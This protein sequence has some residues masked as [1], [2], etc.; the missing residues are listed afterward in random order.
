VFLRLVQSAGNTQVFCGLFND[1]VSSTDRL[2]SNVSDRAAGSSAEGDAGAVV[3]HFLGEF[4]ENHDKLGLA[5]VAAESRIEV[6]SAT[7]VLNCTTAGMLILGT[8]VFRWL[9]SDVQV[10]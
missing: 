10:M 3:S 2:P 6:W 5:H 7:A 8:I 4:E 1:V 9:T